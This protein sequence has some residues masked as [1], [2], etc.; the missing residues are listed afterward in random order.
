MKRNWFIAAAVA[1]LLQIGSL[2][3]AAQ[4][5]T[6]GEFER[7]TPEFDRIVPPDAKIEIVASGFAWSEGP[8]WRK[9]GGF[10][11]FS[12]APNNVINRWTEEDS[13]TV[14]LRPA[15]WIWGPPEGK[16]EHGS[17]GLIEDFNGNLL[18]A[19][20]GNRLI[21]RLDETTWTKT[22]LADNYQGK[23]FN[24]PNDMVQHP[25][26]SIYFTDPPYGLEGIQNSPLREL[27][28]SGVYRISPT[29]EVTLLTDE[30]TFPNG[31]GLS[32]DGKTLYVA[33]TTQP[34]IIKAYDVQPDGSIANGRVFFDPATL[35]RRG[36]FDGMVVDQEGRVWATGPGGVLVIAPDGRHLGTIIT[37][38]GSA[39]VTFG[40]DGTTLFITSGPNLL[41]IRGLNTKG[42]GF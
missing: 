32:P 20:H 13:I 22:I 31:I 35:N 7:L 21:A 38:R 23:K 15:G 11:L 39:N 12:D 36:G 26:G 14:Y 27:D 1:S 9:Q 40:E 28:I 17:N 41:R 34:A 42:I 10:L 4:Y 29:G 18:I 16:R 5:Q 19:D 6:T 2:P 37:G 3:A 30:F 25:D 8:V 24:S 33:S